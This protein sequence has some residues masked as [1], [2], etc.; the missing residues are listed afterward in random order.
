MCVRACIRRYVC[1]SAHMYVASNINSIYIV[2]AGA[3]KGRISYF[4]LRGAKILE[5]CGGD[6]VQCC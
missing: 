2:T 4:S 3:S 1:T 5:V 6:N